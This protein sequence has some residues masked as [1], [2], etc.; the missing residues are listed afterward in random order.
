MNGDTAMTTMPATGPLRGARGGPRM[1]P[2]RWVTL[3]LGVPVALALIGGA[4]FSAVAELGQSSYPVSATIPL[5]NGHL[6][7]SLGGLDVTL[8]QD[9]ARGSTARLAGTV[10]YSLIRPDFTVFG[11]DVSLHCRIFTGNCGLSGTL[12]VPAGTPVDLTSGG[13]NMQVS[14]MQGNVTLDSGG[15]DVTVSGSGGVTYLSTGGGNVT[16]SDLGGTLQFYTAGGDVDGNGLSAP[17]AKLYTG[18]GNVTLMFTKVPAS[19]TIVSGGGDV[20]L[21][22]PPGSTRYHVIHT[23]AGGDYSNSVPTDK[24]SG[25]LIDVQSGGGNVTIAEA[26]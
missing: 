26:G 10:Q 17:Y 2:G 22:L 19:V 15:G 11:A 12:D 8:H 5:K 7:A 13:G 3:L 9:Q 16:A 20:S 24:A 14:N 1:T 21:V 18:G 25:N 23:T 4:G 6:V